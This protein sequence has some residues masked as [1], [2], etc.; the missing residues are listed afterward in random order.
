V[1]FTLPEGVMPPADLGARRMAGGVMEFAP[2]DLTVALH[3]LTGWA[4]DS[5]LSLESLRVLR[6]SLED[7][8]LQLTSSTRPALQVD[9]P[10]DPSE[11]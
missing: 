10:S 4:L 5:S 3:R 8:Y 9:D 6:P 7:V 2:E 1:T 11:D